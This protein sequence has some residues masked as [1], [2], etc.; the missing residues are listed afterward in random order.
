MV[1]TGAVLRFKP[2]AGT[3]ILPRGILL[4]L[5]FI[6][7]LFHSQSMNVFSLILIIMLLMTKHRVFFKTIKLM[8]SEGKS[9]DRNKDIEYQ[10]K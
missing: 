7:E 8:C 5:D 9:Y 3:I 6:K 4:A 10:N 2:E 1:V